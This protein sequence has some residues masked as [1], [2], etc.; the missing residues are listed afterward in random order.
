VDVATREAV[1]DDRL[2]ELA[3]AVLARLRQA[4][5]A[6]ATARTRAAQLHA[7]VVRHLYR[8]V[9]GARGG[10]GLS[11]GAEVDGVGRP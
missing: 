10:R 2:Q 4:A 1:V 6:E 9:R 7:S 5:E 3:R 8:Y 11:D